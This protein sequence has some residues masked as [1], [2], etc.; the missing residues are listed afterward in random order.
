[1]SNDLF[2]ITGCSGSGKSTM[3]EELH[4]RLK[5]NLYV[6]EF[7]D[8][9]FPV[10]NSTFKDWVDWRVYRTQLMVNSALS[11]YVDRPYVICGVVIPCE[12]Y[13]FNQYDGNVHF[14]SL[15]MENKVIR[16]RLKKRGW[17]RDLINCNLDVNVHLK[18][19]MQ[20]EFDGCTVETDKHTVE[21]TGAILRNWIDDIL[22]A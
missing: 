5:D 2:I 9:T 8:D 19:L 16:S 4:Y 10:E 7:D 11:K 12:F 1:M 14:A 21:E 13:K 20:R 15:T 6:Y 17:G 22:G 18:W 3:V